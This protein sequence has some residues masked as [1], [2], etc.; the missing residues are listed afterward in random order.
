MA[1][2]H[3]AILAA[4]IAGFGTMATAATVGFAPSSFA[5]RDTVTIHYQHKAAIPTGRVLVKMIVRDGANAS[6]NIIKEDSKWVTFVPGTLIDVAFD[7]IPELGLKATGV[8]LHAQAMIIRNN[9]QVGSFVAN[10]VITK[11]CTKSGAGYGKA[12]VRTCRWK[13]FRP[14]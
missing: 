6:A 14:F 13:R 4:A 7:P 2:S 10:R 3:V 8:K 12:V 9:D 1:N 5:D 11:V